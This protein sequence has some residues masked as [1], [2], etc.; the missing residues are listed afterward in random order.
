MV[1]LECLTKFSSDTVGVSVHCVG[2]LLIAIY[3][4]IYILRRLEFS[5]CRFTW[6]NVSYIT[7]FF[8]V[9]LMCISSF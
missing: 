5:K 3:I 8:N 7:S 1:T 2:M 6:T 9:L 4:Y